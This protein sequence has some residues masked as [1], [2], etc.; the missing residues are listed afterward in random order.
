M[1]TAVA[2]LRMLHRLWRY[3]LRTE[4]ESLSFLLRQP[5]HGTL[6]MDI[7]ANRGIYAYWMSRAV[8]RQGRV[9]AFEPQPELAHHLHDLKSS[10]ALGNLV[11]VGQGLSSVAGRRTL[12]RPE[13]GAGGASLEARPAG[14][15]SV[16]V[17]LTTLDDYYTDA[18]PVRFIKCDVE[19]HECDV[20]RGARR[21]LVRDRPILLLE[22]HAGEME[23]GHIGRYLSELGYHGFFFCGRRRIDAA[24]FSEF[25]YRKPWEVHRNYVF[26]HGGAALPG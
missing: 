11:I 7:G 8:G 19:G 16:Q 1:L 25:P 24:R 2:K 17:G 20:L 4:R 10:F 18:R 23:K 12:F 5:L 6:V 21:I 3:R 26:V 13:V 22:I 9:I 15:G 14:W